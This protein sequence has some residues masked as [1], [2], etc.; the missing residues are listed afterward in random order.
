MLA[1]CDCSVSRRSRVCLQAVNKLQA[2]DTS[3][4]VIPDPKK[5]Q[6]KKGCVFYVNSV[7]RELDMNVH[8]VL[9]AAGDAGF[10]TLEQLAS[11]PTWTT[12]RAELAL[13]T[14]IKE[15]TCLVDDGH[16]QGVR[17]FWFPSAGSFDD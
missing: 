5:V 14:M 15:G 8:D 7:P 10:V 16:P 4:T 2:L 1:T 9:N 13:Q 3:F 11:R 17:L 6:S 12:R